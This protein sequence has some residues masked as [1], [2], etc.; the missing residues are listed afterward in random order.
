MTVPAYSRASS[1]SDL[2]QWVVHLVRHIGE[3]TPGYI[4]SSFD[5]LRSIL[6]EG[7]IRPSTAPFI[8][9]Y[10]PAGAACFYDAPPHVWPEIVN[11]NPNA[12]QPFGLIVQKTV[13]WHLGG[14]PAIYTDQTSQEYWPEQERYR[15]IHT[16]L[17]RYPQPVD[18]THEREW[19]VPGPLGLYQPNI[20]YEWWWPLVPS[21]DFA[22]SI[23]QDYPHITNIFVMS[24]QGVVAP[25]PR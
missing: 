13:L 17:T 10:F 19:R 5:I 3:I 9:N 20:P 24:R 21:D 2:S 4:G 25:Y 22:Q 23:W 1:R 14:R 11:T 7:C 16:N 6:R 8:T 18:W 15:I 12:R